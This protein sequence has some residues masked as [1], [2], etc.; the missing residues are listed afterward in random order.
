M[1]AD[2]IEIKGLAYRSIIGYS[3]YY[4]SINGEIYSSKS[5]R[6]LMTYANKKDG[7]RNMKAS[8][9]N[10]VIKTLSISR[11]VLL[12]WRTNPN[13]KMFT[14][15]IHKDGNFNNLHVSNLQ[16]GTSAT[17]VLRKLKRHPELIEKMAISV[18]KRIKEHGTPTQKMTMK[19]EEELLKYREI[20]YSA[21]QLA[22]IFPIGKSQVMNIINKHNKP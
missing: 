9:G 16:W 19:L 5:N 15:A 12:A 7:V 13:P 4:A 10:K 21:R 20:G 2:E 6:I 3:G 8:L 14:H 18:R 11:C 1:Q 22:D 17:S